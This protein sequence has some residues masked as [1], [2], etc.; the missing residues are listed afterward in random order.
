MKLLTVCVPCYNS[1]DYMAHCIDSLLPGGDGVEILIVDDGSTD[2]TG[3]IADKYEKAYPGICRAVHK[4]NGGHGSGVNIGIDLAGGKF[5][6]VVDSDDWV[7][8]DVF[9]K[10]LDKL[11]Q[12]TAAGQNL[13]LMI[14]NFTY[15]KEGTE[16][17]K[18]IHYEAALPVN[19]LFGW[20]DVG[21]FHKGTYLLMHSVIYRTEVL[22]EA[23]LR[24]PEHCFYVDNLY[25][26]QP[27]PFVKDMY[28]MNVNLYDYYIGRS[29]QSV[30]EKVMISRLDQQMKVTKLMIAY[31][32]NRTMTEKIRKY[33]PL[34]DY[35]YNY[36]EIIVTISSVLAM[37]SDKPEDRK[38]KDELWGYLKKRDFWLYQRMRHGIFG[39]F[40]GSDNRGA[41]FI[42]VEGYRLIHHF[43]QFN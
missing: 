37:L 20:S 9:I 17:H 21:R 10:V 28:Y 29:D 6:K 1:Q 33:K 35:M 26:F 25:V 12:L 18:V 27:L 30:N 4:P 7:E 8:T 43:F 14:S 24:L 42:S 41:R 40:V 13:D 34:Q 39:T 31:Y 11:D 3:E 5:F 36:L 19:Q 15:M 32:T 22:K 23:G 2:A 16:N 38:M